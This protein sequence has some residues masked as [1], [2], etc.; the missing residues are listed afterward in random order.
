[1]IKF[2]KNLFKVENKDNSKI[3]K[4]DCNILLDKSNSLTINYNK[5][6]SYLDNIYILNDNNYIYLYK[7]SHEYIKEIHYTIVF[8]S[9]LNSSFNYLYEDLYNIKKKDYQYKL[10][11]EEKLIFLKKHYKNLN[12]KKIINDFLLFKKVL[13]KILI[14]LKTHNNLLFKDWKRG[15]YLPGVNINLN[16]NYIKSYNIYNLNDKLLE[17][18]KHFIIQFKFKLYID[19]P[20]RYKN[21][22]R[23]ISKLNFLFSNENTKLFKNYYFYYNLHYFNENCIYCDL[24]KKWFSLEYFLNYSFEDWFVEIFNIYYNIKLTRSNIYILNYSFHLKSFIMKKNKKIYWNN[25]QL[26]SKLINKYKDI[27]DD[28]DIKKVV[29]NIEFNLYNKN[30]TV[31]KLNKTPYIICYNSDYIHYFY[32]R[33][34]PLLNSDFIT[35]DTKC[36][37]YNNRYNLNKFRLSKQLYTIIEFLN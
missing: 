30:W 16:Y 17:Q 18:D 15:K 32:N 19:L 11:D 33:Y 10:F 22:K 5:V 31:E 13:K 25:K 9:I 3:V 8:V 20:K 28:F 7:K 37:K 21:K 1:M 12:N 35:L 27:F 14:N 4:D 6:K 26:E 23:L 34:I 29:Y 36:K 24:K 2:L